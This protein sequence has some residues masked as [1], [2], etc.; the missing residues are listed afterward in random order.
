M[1]RSFLKEC[2]LVCEFATKVASE[3]CCDKRQLPLLCS[4]SGQDRPWAVGS[5][6]GIRILRRLREQDWLAG[7]PASTHHPI[8]APPLVP[9]F[10]LTQIQ[11]IDRGTSKVPFV[12][13]AISKPWRC[14]VDINVSSTCS[15]GS[16]PVKTTNRCSVLPCHCAR[17]AAVKISAPANEPPS[18]PSVPT[19]SVSQKEQTALS[20][21]CSRPTTDCSQKTGRTPRSDRPELLR[22]GV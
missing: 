10:G 22:P 13:M 9:A 12:S 11:S 5:D 15:I 16:P 19:K 17:I 18:G 4:L 6:S 3:D 8:V 14:N 7:R 2:R 20:R 1:N 21:S